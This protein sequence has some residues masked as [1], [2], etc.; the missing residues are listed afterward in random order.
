[1]AAR[2][3]ARREVARQAGARTSGGRGG[4]GGGGGG[5]S[6]PAR[7]VRARAAPRQADEPAARS[8]AWSPKPGS[9]NPAAR[10]LASPSDERPEEWHDLVVQLD[11]EEWQQARPLA[12]VLPAGPFAE[13]VL[14]EGGDLDM[15]GFRQQ[16]WRTNIDKARYRARMQPRHM[17]PFDWGRDVYEWMKGTDY[18]EDRQRGEM[19]MRMKGVSEMD[20]LPW[21]PF[22]EL[23][24]QEHGSMSILYEVESELLEATMEHETRTGVELPERYAW[25]VFEL[26]GH[27]E[28]EEWANLA[29]QAM[30]RP[31]SV[32]QEYARRVRDQDFDL[33]KGPYCAVNPGEQEIHELFY[34][35]VNG[36]HDKAGNHFAV[37]R[38]L[39]DRAALCET[40][41]N[42]RAVSMDPDEFFNHPHPAHMAM[43]EVAL[44]TELLDEGDFLKNLLY[45]EPEV[46]FNMKDQYARTFA[47]KKAAWAE[48][49]QVAQRRHAQL[50]VR[51][52]QQIQEAFVDAEARLA[53]TPRFV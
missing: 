41:L 4:G 43:A 45:K 48:E 46:V 40:E 38:A 19:E 37:T 6:Q 9:W 33:Y 31:D 47:L 36:A 42:E 27:E 35:V 8:P 25:E 7:Q 50:G 13:K 12:E 10:Q 20:K 26:D 52:V 44:E 5:G 16:D 17:Y 22:L 30:N 23:Y 14:A 28:V 53:G 34:R 32:I 2:V 51:T 24:A 21:S 1:M 18:E 49:L 39:I 11:P 29:E 15:P 3:Q